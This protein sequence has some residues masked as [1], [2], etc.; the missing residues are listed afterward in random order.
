M[1]EGNEAGTRG[2]GAGERDQGDGGGAGGR[3]RSEVVG[4]D[5]QRCV[6]V[7]FV[8]ELGIWFWGG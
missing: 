8:V 5:G 6:R 2:E 7:V 4:N 1:S 3:A